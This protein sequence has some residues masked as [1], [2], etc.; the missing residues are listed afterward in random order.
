MVALVARA[1][2]KL[3]LSLSLLGRRQD[4]YHLLHSLVAFTRF[5]DWLTLE[6]GAQLALEVEGDL[7]SATGPVADNLVLSA[8]HNFAAL[9][10]GAPLGRFHLTKRIPVAAGLGGGSSDAAAALRLLAK[11]HGV[12]RDD[13]LLLEAARRTGADVSVCLAARPRFMGGI[14]DELGPV[15]D[16][17][18]LIGVLVNPGVALATRA[19]FAALR[20]QPGTTAL[21]AP[22]PLINAAMTAENLVAALRR[23][24]NDMEDA[25]Q[26]LAPVIVGVLAVLSGA[27]GCKLAR[28]TGSGATCFGLFTSRHAARAAVA[29]IRRGHPEWWVKASVIG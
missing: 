27:P 4:S 15:L 8:A 9:F 5:G 28:M 29:A 24:G 22:A 11:A 16:L 25:S 6:P 10:P 2:A 20:L 14:G 18:P 12:A 21:A 3:N 17:P 7:A 13:G 26:L 1:P 23:S 19:V